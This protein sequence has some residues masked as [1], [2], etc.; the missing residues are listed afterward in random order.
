MDNPLHN[1][2]IYNQYVPQYVQKFM[3]LGLYRDTFDEF[4]LLLPPGAGILEL[5]CGPGNVVKYLK[6]KRTDLDILGIDLAPEM[7]K[8]AESQNPDA[9]F[10]LMDIRDAGQ[11]NRQFDAVVAAFS[12]PYISYEDVAALFRDIGHLTV[13]NGLLYLSCMEGPKERSGWEKTSFTGDSKMH[14]NY[15]ER[16]EIEDL[17]KAHHFSIEQFYTKDYPEEDGSTTID[18]VFIARKAAGG[19]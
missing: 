17:L 9:R 16:A 1:I 18:L 15:F 5:G 13:A 8:E 19:Q 4:M 2:N 3:D 10:Q 6:E 7:I 14:I 11:L 12:L